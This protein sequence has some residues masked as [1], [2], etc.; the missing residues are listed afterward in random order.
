[1]V[2]IA[3]VIMV[4]LLGQALVAQ[5][6]TPPREPREML[7]LAITSNKSVE[8]PVGGKTAEI[9]LARTRS[10]GVPYVKFE[11]LEDFAHCKVVKQSLLVPQLPDKNGD[12]VGDWVLVTKLGLCPDGKQPE[13]LP[14]VTFLACSI[15][16]KPCPPMPEETMPQKR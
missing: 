14:A 3:N 2:K 15:G 16:G 11:P 8:G 10:K 13:G 5:A 4:A 9:V 7:E 6:D 12:I 1:M